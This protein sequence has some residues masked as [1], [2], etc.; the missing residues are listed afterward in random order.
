M[1]LMLR[2][3]PKENGDADRKFPDYCFFFLYILKETTAAVHYYV[4]CV[5]IS[6]RKNTICSEEPANAHKAQKR[7]LMN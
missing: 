5:Y 2:V 6:Q 3:K 1:R 4:L 7:G